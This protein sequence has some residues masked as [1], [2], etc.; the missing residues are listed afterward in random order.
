MDVR[1]RHSL[2]EMKRRDKYYSKT[3]SGFKKVGFYNKAQ[4]KEIPLDS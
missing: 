4:A 1:E 2:I 3:E